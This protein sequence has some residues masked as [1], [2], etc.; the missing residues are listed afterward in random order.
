VLGGDFFCGPTFDRDRPSVCPDFKFVIKN[1][2]L[3]KA[4]QDAFTAQQSSAVEIVVKQNEA[5]QAKTTAE[6]VA[7]QQ[8][9]VQASS[10][11]STWSTSESSP[12]LYGPAAGVH[13][14]HQ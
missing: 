7:A 2:T 11:P 6:G 5:S 4:L 8:N 13:P 12:R 3:P 1:I 14:C 9:A 10:P